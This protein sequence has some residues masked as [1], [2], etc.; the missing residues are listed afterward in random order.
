[1]KCILVF[2]SIVIGGLSDADVILVNDTGLPLARIEIDG[3]Q[4][5]DG[6]GLPPHNKILISATPANHHLKLIF[7]GGAKIEWPHL[8]FS[9]VHEIF[10][11]RDHNKI[12]ARVE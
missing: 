4:F 11:Q 9:G 3:R 7:R 2:A 5:Q 10:F 6:T 8:N 1:M 12:E